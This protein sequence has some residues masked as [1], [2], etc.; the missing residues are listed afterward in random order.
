VL[1][2]P[3]GVSEILTANELKHVFL[4]ELAHLNRRDIAVDLL[5]SVLCRL[6]WFNPLIWMAAGRM[7]VERELACDEVVLRV[8]GA[9]DA[10]NYG[11]TIIRLVEKPRRGE[12]PVGLTGFAENKTQIKRRL[13]MLTSFKKT[14]C[15]SIIGLAMLA[16]VGLATFTSAQEPKKVADE[17]VVKG[18][19]TQEIPSPY[20][21]M[22]KKLELTGKEL[23]AFTT[24]ANEAVKGWKVF[25]K[26]HITQRRKRYEE[27]CK[28]F[29]G[30]D[31]AKRRQLSV[32]HQE[33]EK[34]YIEAFKEKRTEFRK[35]VLSL[36]TID[37]K[38]Y[39]MSM[40]IHQQVMSYLSGFKLTDSQN[41]KITIMIAQAA[42]DCIQRGDLLQADKYILDIP[43]RIP[44]KEIINKAFQ[45]VVTTEQL[46]SRSVTSLQNL[47]KMRLKGIELTE[48]QR[49]DIARILQDLAEEGVRKEQDRST[50][51][52]AS[53]G[54]MSGFTEAFNRIRRDILTKEQLLDGIKL[55]MRNQVTHHHK[56]V[57]LTDDQEKQLSAAIA[58]DAQKR[59]EKE[60]QV[61]QLPQYGRNAWDYRKLQKTV[62]NILTSAQRLKIE[63]HT[64]ADCA[65]A[66][67]SIIG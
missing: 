8:T 23:G 14:R 31:E 59:L 5:A 12:S 28:S 27:L 53:T 6:H 4:H 24:K 16:I 1:L 9:T 19:K 21:D 67:S 60:S 44:A 50:F 65:I 49:K 30:L 51:M 18:V 46:V 66:R 52:Y 37:Q 39:L 45:D 17:P 32:E 36:L 40:Y 63:I 58:A 15:A 54:A 3:S 38:G 42:K 7:R 48:K 57:T 26:D 61:G 10:R 2:L 29:E 35:S 43:G 22:A 11:R 64:M 33:G 20:D 56:Y 55:E 25:D 34:Q 47:V 62:S 13:K 41:A